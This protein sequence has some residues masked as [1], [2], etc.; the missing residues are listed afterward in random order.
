MLLYNKL[1]LLLTAFE[2]E[3]KDSMGT[4]VPYKTLGFSSTY[5]LLVSCPEVVEIQILESGQ[6]LLVGVP[7]ENTEHMAR[8][9]GEQRNEQRGF[10]YLTGQVLNSQSIHVKRKIEK[11]SGKR[12]RVIPAFIKNQ[13]KEL[14]ELEEYQEGLH[15]WEFLTAYKDLYDYQLEFKSYGFHNL[16]D[17]LH[18]GLEDVVRL[19][20]D[21][22]NKEWRIIPLNLNDN[23][24]VSSLPQEVKENVRKLLSSRPGGVEVCD[25]PLVYTQLGEELNP[26]SLGYS[27]IEELCILMSDV[28]NYLP[29]TQ[30]Q[31][32]TIK[33]IQEVESMCI[34]PAVPDH[35]VQ[36]IHRVF[37]DNPDGV[38]V[39][40]VL[41]KYLEVT[42]DC[43]DVSKL[44]L[45]SLYDL[46]SSLSGSV[47]EVVQENVKLLGKQVNTRKV[48]QLKSPRI[49]SGNCWA[50]VVT[51][52][53][54]VYVQVEEDW[55]RLVKLEDEMEAYYR[56][57]RTSNVVS[58]ESI[59]TG[60][61]VVCLDDGQGVWCRGR[62]TRVMEHSV[63]VS[64]LDYGH[65]VK[66]PISSV[67]V[68]ESVFAVLPPV[69][70]SLGSIMA[71]LLEVGDIVWLQPGEE[72]AVEVYTSHGE[73]L[74][75]VM[76]GSSEGLVY[77]GE[78]GEEERSREELEII[79]EIEMRNIVLDAM[80][81]HSSL[82][83]RE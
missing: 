11:V 59:V 72:G 51:V 21:V 42:G 61:D 33:P 76:T 27:D 75:E 1:G 58:V 32:P 12:S 66:V 64:C 67:R 45:S 7:D 10:D 35:I 31:E 15:L 24:E 63:E 8:M 37:T 74:V 40:E 81:K 6:T 55:E 60:L 57:E 48:N 53:E 78:R 44:G 36:N 79:E 30:H 25:L 49:L 50:E 28:C 18:H 23:C 54:T 19:S 14:M 69:A 56:R 82:G 17:M 46:L 65:S 20:L 22:Y 47:L 34:S 41:E 80:G 73:G 39:K 2:R 4:I 29:A 38:T 16:M 70:V 77:D 13:V 5:D 26:V 83:G 71:Q 52:Q 3:Y 62:V 43:L 68:L 9:V